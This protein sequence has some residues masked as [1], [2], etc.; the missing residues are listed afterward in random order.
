MSPSLSCLRLMT[1]EGGSGAKSLARGHM[2]DPRG[3]ASWCARPLELLSDRRATGYRRPHA[4]QH[5]HPRT[6]PALVQ[7]VGMHATAI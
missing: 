1:S 5:R 7:T 4:V 2:P 3:S 6:R